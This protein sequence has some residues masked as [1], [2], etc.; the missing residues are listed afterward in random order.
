MREL[1]CTEIRHFVDFRWLLPGHLFW[2]LTNRSWIFRTATTMM[3]L[4]IEHPKSIGANFTGLESDCRNS[5][6]TDWCSGHRIS[7]KLRARTHQ[8]VIIEDLQANCD[9]TTWV[10]KLV[11]ML[12]KAVWFFWWSRCWE[13]FES[14]EIL[15]RGTSGEVD[16][17]VSSHSDKDGHSTVVVFRIGFEVLTI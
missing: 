3:K 8:C 5:Y 16:I 9:E 1:Q 4:P 2:I 7:R 17:E 14:D 11:R 15:N 12:K 13:V 10:S 6:R